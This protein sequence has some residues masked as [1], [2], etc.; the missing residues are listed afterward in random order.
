MIAAFAGLVLAAGCGGNS[1]KDEDPH[2]YEACS[3]LKQSRDESLDSTNRMGL[4]LAIGK[5]AVKSIDSVIR[6]AVNEDEEL[7][8]LQGSMGSEDAEAG[9]E[10]MRFMDVDEE[11]L[12]LA[13]E[14]N[15]F[16]F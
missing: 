3:L 15:G 8:D 14:A 5:E 4:S 6:V 7:E 16:D 13:C 10:M 9:L 1:F 11:I 2:G 12:Q